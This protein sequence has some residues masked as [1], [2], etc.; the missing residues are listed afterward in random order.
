MARVLL[1]YHS[2]GSAFLERD[3]GAAGFE[4]VARRMVDADVLA[5]EHGADV[6]VIESPVRMDDLRRLVENPA[7]GPKTPLVVLL[8]PDQLGGLEPTLP[9][10]DFVLIPVAAEELVL[11][12]R[13]LIWRKTGLDEASVVRYGELVMDLANY[14]VYVGDTPVSLTYKEFELLRFLMVN[15]GKV[16]TREALLNRVWG[17]EYYGGART[18][19]VHIR[20][21]RS[22]IESGSTVYIE[23]VRNVGYRFPA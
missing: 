10:D 13:R 6:I 8:R 16:F 23:T 7:R 12:L 17:Y 18:V 5:E 20:R 19:D 2:E 22:K 4:V 15:R 11:R 9:I 3:L 14:K 1:A 21:L